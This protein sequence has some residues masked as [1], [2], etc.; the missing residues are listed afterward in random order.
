MM[1]LRVPMTIHTAGD[2]Q[3]QQMTKTS[4]KCAMLR[5]VTNKGVFRRYQQKYEY[6]LEAFT[7]TLP[8]STFGSKYAN[9]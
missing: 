5:E 1:A 4:S 7:F 9:S 8:L 2:H 3:L 6:Q